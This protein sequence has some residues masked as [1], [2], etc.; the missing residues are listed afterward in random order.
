[1]KKYISI[2]PVRAGSKGIKLKNIKELKG[3]PLFLYSVEQSLRITK[4]CLISTDIK[5]ILNTRFN[6]NVFVQERKHELAR[7]KTL[8]RDVLIDIFQSNELDEYHCILLQATSP[9]RSDQDIFNAIDIYENNNYKLVLS[10][11]QKDST[12]LKY[13]FLSGNNFQPIDS[14]K[15]LF[16]NRQDLPKVYSPNGAIYI[17]SVSEFV[18]AADFPTKSIGAYLMPNDRSLDIDSPEDF[19]EAEKYLIHE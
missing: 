17:F 3:K 19:I 6:S 9:L 14:S 18:E 1:M 11:S 7:D 10:I 2:V 8:M 13:G 5:Q 12:I 15:S 16:T 4:N